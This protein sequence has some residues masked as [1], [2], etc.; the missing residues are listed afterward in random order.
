MFENARLKVGR[1]KKHIL[2]FDREDAAFFASDACSFSFIKDPKVGKSWFQFREHKPIPPNFPL[3]VGDAV[4]NL[5]SALDQMM[6]EI[7]SPLSPKRPDRVQ[8][9]I[10]EKADRL[11]DAIK[12]REVQIAGKKVLDAIRKTEPYL[13]G[14]YD[15]FWLDKLD[16]RDKHKI[17][18]GVLPLIAPTGFEREGIKISPD[19][20]RLMAVAFVPGDQ[21]KVGEVPYRP[22]LTRQQ[23]RSV[24]GLA[25]ALRKRQ[26]EK[27]TADFRSAFGRDEPFGG[28]PVVTALVRLT[29]TVDAIIDSM[30]IACS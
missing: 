8:F 20:A 26:E 18:I 27:L 10:C 30:Q 9:P 1:A 6:W 29:E 11:E 12:S 19:I 22:P 25:A 13:G 4:H 21:G 28:Q 17:V 16:I 14:K 15:L 2:D 24:P 23:R 5:R 3:I 7:V